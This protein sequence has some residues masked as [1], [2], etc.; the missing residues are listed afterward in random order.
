M[1]ETTGNH[2]QQK[3]DMKS[4]VRYYCHVGYVY[5]IEHTLHS[6]DPSIQQMAEEFEPCPFYTRYQRFEEHNPNS[7]FFLNDY[8]MS[9]SHP[10]CMDIAYMTQ[11]ASVLKSKMTTFTRYIH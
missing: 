8:N 5:W 9:H 11:K 1:A 2:E 7:P 6:N 3:N 10:L 4:I